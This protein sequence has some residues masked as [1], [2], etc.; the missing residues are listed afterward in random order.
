MHMRVEGKH[1]DRAGGAL[2]TKEWKKQ[3]LSAALTHHIHIHG[4]SSHPCQEHEQTPLNSFLGQ[5]WK[6]GIMG[7]ICY[8]SGICSAAYSWPLTL[9]TVTNFQEHISLWRSVRS[10][11]GKRVPVQCRISGKL[12]LHCLIQITENT[13]N[14]WEGHCSDL[15]FNAKR[16]WILTESSHSQ[17]YKDIPSKTTFWIRKG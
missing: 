10:S 9:Q 6:Q 3:Q 14:Q 12:L 13:V 17:I 16:E 5:H 11:Q 1:S 7:V 8:P 15:S 4:C 2:K